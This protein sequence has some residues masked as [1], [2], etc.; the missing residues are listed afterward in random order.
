VVKRLQERGLIGWHYKIPTEAVLA[1]EALAMAPEF[2]NGG[3]VQ[4]LTIIRNMEDKGLISPLTRKELERLPAWRRIVDDP[5]FLKA[6]PA[7]KRKA[8]LKLSRDRLISES[9]GADLLAV[10]R[11]EPATGTHE[12]SPDPMTRDLPV[13]AASPPSSGPSSQHESG[14]A[15]R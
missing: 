15:P 4:R 11:L 14:R 2:Q 6:D 3:P 13:P 9:T 1:A 7:G 12:L 8:I 5:A 10:F